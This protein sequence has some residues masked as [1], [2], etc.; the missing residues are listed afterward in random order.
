LYET[1]SSILKGVQVTLLGQGLEGDWWIIDNP[2]YP[3]VSCWLPGDALDIDPNL[4]LSSLL[5][6]PAPPVP[7][8][9]PTLITGCLYQ[10]PNDNQAVCYP[11]AQCP[12]PFHQTQGACTP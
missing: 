8:L 3:G 2:R 4:D 7:T 10:G 11:I 9:T 5:L 1:V 12:V 6:I